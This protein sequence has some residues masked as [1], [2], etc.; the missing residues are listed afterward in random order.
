MDARILVPVQRKHVEH[1]RA[2]RILLRDA[3]L[4][5]LALKDGIVVVAILD[6]DDDGRLLWST[7]RSVIGR[8]DPELIAG[9]DFAIQRL[10]GRQPAGLFVDGEGQG[11]RWSAGGCRRIVDKGVA[12]AR[13]FA[14]VA[15]VSLDI[16]ELTR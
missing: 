7:R 14:A 11:V 2:G 1:R 12:D 15:V 6:L 10:G 5:R 8:F 4:V 3:R 16:V 13:V 9:L